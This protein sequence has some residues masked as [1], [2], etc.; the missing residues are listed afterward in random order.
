M[1]CFAWGLYVSTVR[2]LGKH[3]NKDRDLEGLLAEL[4]S[5]SACAGNTASSIIRLFT[6]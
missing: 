1:A 2:M 5:A 6:K 3:E 4:I